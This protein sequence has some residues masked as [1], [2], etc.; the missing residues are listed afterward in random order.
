MKKKQKSG[1][2]NKIETM[3]GIASGIPVYCRFDEIINIEKAIAHPKNPNTHPDRQIEL[4][5]RIIRTQGWRAPITISTRSNFIVRGHARLAAAKILAVKEVPIEYQYY[6][7]ENSELEDMIADNKIADFAKVDRKI[8]K[9]LVTDMQARGADLSMTGMDSDELLRLLKNEQREPDVEAEKPKK[10]RTKL[11][12]VWELGKHRLICGDSTKPETF[13]K[14][15]EGKKAHLLF[16]DPPYGVNYGENSK[17]LNRNAGGKRKGAKILGDNLKN[18]DLINALLLPA[19]KLAYQSTRDDAAF[20]IWHASSTKS[21]F[22]WAIRAA[23]LEEKQQLIWIKPAF[24]LGRADYHYKHEPCIYAQKIGYKARMF[25]NR[26]QATV[27]EFEAVGTNK[28]QFS[29]GNGIRLSMESGMEIF[30]KKQ[31]P[32]S[33]KGRLMRL[34]DGEKLSLSVDDSNSDTWFITPDTKSAYIHPTQK[35]SELAERAIRNHT[36]PEDTVLDV[37]SGSGSTLIAAEKTERICRAS[38]IDASYCDLTVIRYA[39][40]CKLNERA[41]KIKLN[42]QDVTADYKALEV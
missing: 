27:W 25:G 28:G 3:K 15:M 24:V 9:G 10:T 8:L 34:K 21:E 35:P 41:Y 14:L 32:K 29:I 37:F 16:T 19:L 26:D 1:K 17:Q 12:D 11:G 13:S 39:R 36:S 31:A 18:N 20:F 23:N 7:D 2:Q 22:D 6:K 33:Y 38:E 42:G 5:S 4:L 40:F 30:I